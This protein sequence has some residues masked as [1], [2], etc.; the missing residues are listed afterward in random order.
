MT[1]AYQS[2][3]THLAPANHYKASARD[4][5]ALAL[6]AALLFVLLTL[7]LSWQPWVENAGTPEQGVNQNQ[8]QN[9]QPNTERQVAPVVP[10]ITGPCGCG[11]QSLEASGP[12]D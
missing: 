7:G 10:F 9:V 6:G 3:Y 11:A 12:I 4:I 5:M 2:G 8:Q 1:H